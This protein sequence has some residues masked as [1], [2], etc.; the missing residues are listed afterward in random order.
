MQHY[1]FIETVA[2][3]VY[4][5]RKKLP[6]AFKETFN[7][8]MMVWVVLVPDSNYSFSIYGEKLKQ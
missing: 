5:G 4:P 3:A 8:L 1:T 2:N 6:S 7:I